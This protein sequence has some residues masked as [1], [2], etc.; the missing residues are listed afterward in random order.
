[1]SRHCRKASGST[2]LMVPQPIG[3][4]GRSC[5][6]PAR[7]HM[8]VFD[9]TLARLAAVPLPATS[10]RGIA[11]VVAPSV[12]PSSEAVHAALAGVQDPE[13]RRPITELGMVKD[14]SVDGGNVT[15]AV[16]LTVAGC[17]M[18]DRIT[19]DVTAAVRA[20]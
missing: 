10:P 7:R 14:V 13:I 4:T 6:E 19:N 11:G 5:S 16:W 3:P 9:V 20:V 18:R 12:P 1:M 15:V 2:T 17:P 8:S